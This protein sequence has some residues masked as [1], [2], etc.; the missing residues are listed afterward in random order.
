MQYLSN[1]R[2]ELSNSRYH[3]YMLIW[4]PRDQFLEGTWCNFQAKHVNKVGPEI[5]VVA[6]IE[7]DG[8]ISQEEVDE[9]KDILKLKVQRPSFDMLKALQWAG[10]IWY[11]YKYVFLWRGKNKDVWEMICFFFF[12]EPSSPCCIGDW[13]SCL[14]NNCIPL[15]HGACLVKLTH[16]ST[17]EMMTLNIYKVCY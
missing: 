1:S 5:K 9:A 16:N 7:K 8:V 11:G 10:G 14:C 6:K 4:N 12:R 13:M 17:P 15:L 3:N 2:R